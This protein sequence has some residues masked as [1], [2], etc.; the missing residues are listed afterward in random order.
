MAPESATTIDATKS[1]TLVFIERPAS[2]RLPETQPRRLVNRIRPGYEPN[3]PQ[4]K[5]QSDERTS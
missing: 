2:D 1:Q 3:S 5:E 4:P